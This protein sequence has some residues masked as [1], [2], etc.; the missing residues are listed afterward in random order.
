MKKFVKSASNYEINVDADFENV[1]NKV[2][3]DPQIVTMLE[4]CVEDFDTRVADVLDCV[5]R[6]FGVHLSAP[7]VEVSAIGDDN[8]NVYMSASKSKYDFGY[9]IAQYFENMLDEWMQD[10]KQL[11]DT[12]VYDVYTEM[13]RNSTDAKAGCTFAVEEK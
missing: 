11:V 8:V 2:Y 10:S 3:F 5:Y 4:D 13:D 1:K 9:V 12:S 7:E 6:N